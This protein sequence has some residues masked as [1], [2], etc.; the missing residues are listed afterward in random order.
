MPCSG[1]EGGGRG[2][3]GGGVVSLIRRRHYAWPPQSTIVITI[4]HEEIGTLARWRHFP[5]TMLIATRMAIRCVGGCVPNKLAS[6]VLVVQHVGEWLIYGSV[7]VRRYLLLRFDITC[8]QRVCE[9]RSAPRSALILDILFPNLR[10]G[11][12]NNS[13]ADICYM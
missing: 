2:G 1:R 12:K 10:K 5:R 3:G 11:L 9:I 13:Y 4:V 8:W 6:M 7:T